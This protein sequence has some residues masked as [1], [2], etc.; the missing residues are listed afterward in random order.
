LWPSLPHETLRGAR[1]CRHFS[2]CDFSAYLHAN[3]YAYAAVHGYAYDVDPVVYDPSRPLPWQ[4]ARAD[5]SG[6]VNRSSPRS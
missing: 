4:K 3:R 1:R 5:R 2:T 6:C